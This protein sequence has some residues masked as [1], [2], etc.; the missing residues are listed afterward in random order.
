MRKWVGRFRKIAETF[1]NSLLDKWVAREAAT[2]E[3]ETPPVIIGV[4][5]GRFTFPESVLYPCLPIRHTKYGLLYVSEGETVATA[6]EALLAIRQ[7]A[8]IDAVHTV[9][10]AP[11]EKSDAC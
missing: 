1:D 10:L 9:E 2:P 5:R 3:G 11:A 6:A 4:V 8:T 7:G